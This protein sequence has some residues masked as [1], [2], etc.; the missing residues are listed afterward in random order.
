MW[1]RLEKFPNIVPRMV[2]FHRDIT[3]LTILGKRYG[4]AG[5]SDI[6][7]EVG[8][9]TAS[10]VFGILEGRQYN[11]ALRAHMIVMEL[12]QRLRLKSF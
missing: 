11:R 12:M 8:I 1:K 4:D 3:F 10:S 6:L 5:L 9:V 7:T 2:A